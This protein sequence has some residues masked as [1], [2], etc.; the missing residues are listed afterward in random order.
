[1]S[2]MH[3]ARY[4]TDGFELI[5]VESATKVVV[6]VLLQGNLSVQVAV[7]D[8]VSLNIALLLLVTALVSM[9]MYL[10]AYKRIDL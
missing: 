2:S 4:E 3:E 8:T 10:Q 9:Y 6:Y 1:M 7:A 5:V